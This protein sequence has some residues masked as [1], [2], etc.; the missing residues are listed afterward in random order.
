MSSDGPK[1]SITPYAPFETPA[2]RTEPAPAPRPSSSPPAFDFPSAVR[3][4]LERVEQ[5]ITEN[6]KRAL[7]SL[8]T[9]VIERHDEVSKRL[10]AHREELRALRAH[11]ENGTT[12]PPPPDGL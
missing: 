1:R 5:S 7:Q 9:L 4:E 10:D 6:V 3:V 8:G 2:T 11:A 12:L